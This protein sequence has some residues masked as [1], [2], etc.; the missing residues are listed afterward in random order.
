MY[1]INQAT[2][3]ERTSCWFFLYSNT[4][5]NRKIGVIHVVTSVASVALA[6]NLVPRPLGGWPGYQVN[7]HGQIESPLCVVRVI[8]SKVYTHM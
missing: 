5:N 4:S 2:R 3:T 7:W 6:C 1:R 8:K